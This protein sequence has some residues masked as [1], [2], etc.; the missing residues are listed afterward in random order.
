MSKLSETLSGLCISPRSMRADEV[1]ERFI[2][3]LAGPELLPF[4]KS[5]LLGQDQALE[6]LV[7][8][9]STECLTRPLH[10]PL[11]YC[12]QGT[13][14]TGKSESTALLAERLGLPCACRRGQ[15]S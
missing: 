12:A 2:R 9:L 4:L 11:C 14:G 6:Q 1:Q 8:R 7:L 3:V 5:R 15:H 10:Q 13:P